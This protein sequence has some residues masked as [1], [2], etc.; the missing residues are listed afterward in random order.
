[1]N[2]PCVHLKKTIDCHQ[3]CKFKLL[4]KNIMQASRGLW[5]FN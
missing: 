2:H 1:M 5:A 4:N 3:A